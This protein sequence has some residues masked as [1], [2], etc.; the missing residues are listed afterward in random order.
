MKPSLLFMASLK[1]ILKNS[2]K[3]ASKY[4]EKRGSNA[5]EKGAN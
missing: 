1:K 3:R 5:P 2:G 4:L